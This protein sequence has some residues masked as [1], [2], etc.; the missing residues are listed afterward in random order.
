MLKKY[1][2]FKKINYG[3]Y[4]QFGASIPTFKVYDIKYKS[5]LEALTH[6]NF[7]ILLPI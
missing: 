1:L 6:N 5:V 3:V 7:H 4:F 2:N